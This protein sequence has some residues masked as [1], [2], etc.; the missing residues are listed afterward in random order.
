MRGEE[1]DELRGV[2]L[3]VIGYD[4]EAPPLLKREKPIPD[5]E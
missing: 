4:N 5:E 1:I 2:D 3:D